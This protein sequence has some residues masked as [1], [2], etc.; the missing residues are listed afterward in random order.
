MSHNLNMFRAHTKAKAACVVAMVA[1]RAY[2]TTNYISREAMRPY[3][4]ALVA[5]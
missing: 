5:E 3:H 1:G 4:L 2:L